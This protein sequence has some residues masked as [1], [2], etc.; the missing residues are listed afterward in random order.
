MI[1][2]NTGKVLS[3]SYRCRICRFCD[4]AIDRVP[5][6]HD[7]RKNWEKSSKAME[8]DMAIEVIHKCLFFILCNIFASVCIKYSKCVLG[9]GFFFYI[10]KL[11]ALT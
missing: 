8:S 4:R 2:S 11:K 1:G 5:K 10:Y 9:G 3:Y 7:C 6:D